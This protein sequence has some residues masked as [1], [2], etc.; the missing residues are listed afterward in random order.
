M[1]ALLLVGLLLA[2]EAAAVPPP[3][4]LSFR[5]F[6]EPSPRELRPSARL[7][8]LA[9]KRVKLVGFMAEMESPPTGGFYLCAAPVT[10]TEAG[11]GT[12][13]LPPDAVFVVVKSAAGKPLQHIAR[14]LEV[15]GVL[16]LGPVTHEDG[17]VS[18]LRVLL[19]G[20]AP[21]STTP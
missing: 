12:A 21:S 3:V 10:A 14:P 11:G 9:G 6:F 5:E 7:L 8:S 20:P 1:T 2:S 16:E 19:D 4:P 17:R 13:D 15:T 18:S